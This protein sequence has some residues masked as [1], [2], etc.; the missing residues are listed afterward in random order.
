MFVREGDHGAIYDKDFTLITLTIVVT[1]MAFF[2]SA[3]LFLIPQSYW[4][5]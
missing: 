3:I 5:L 1:D 2:K 4:R